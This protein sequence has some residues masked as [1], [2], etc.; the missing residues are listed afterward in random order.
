MS[1]LGSAASGKAF[2]ALRR[3][4]KRFESSLS[5]LLVVAGRQ[6]GPPLLGRVD[7]AYAKGLARAH[8]AGVEIL[9]YDTH[10]TLKQIRLNRKL[11]I[12][13]PEA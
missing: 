10:I 9:A 6:F 2:P 7:P 1:H 3:G 11:P 4:R 13:L 5:L 8:A 12:A